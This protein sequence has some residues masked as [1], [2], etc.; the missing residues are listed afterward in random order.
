[1]TRSFFAIPGIAATSP[2][3]GLTAVDFGMDMAGLLVN[4]ALIGKMRPW[5]NN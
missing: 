2:L 3:N 1:V 5:M 4:L